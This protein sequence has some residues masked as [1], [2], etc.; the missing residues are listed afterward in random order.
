MKA[1]QELKREVND[2]NRSN[3]IDSCE[4]IVAKE[5]STVIEDETFFFLPLKNILK[6]ASKTSFWDHDDPTKLMK[7]FIS[8]TI[9][10]HPAEKETVFLLSSIKTGFIQTLDECIDILSLFTQCDICVQLRDRYQEYIATPSLDTDFLIQ[11]KEKEIKNLENELIKKEP[12]RVPLIKKPEDF[13]PN[14]FYAVRD[15]KL[16][17]VRYLIEKEGID[18]DIRNEEEDQNKDTPLFCGDTPLHVACLYG[19][20]QIVDYLLH[21][22]AN[23]DAQNDEGNTPLHYAYVIKQ[24]APEYLISKGANRKIANHDGKIPEESFFTACNI[25]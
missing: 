7:T 13:E 4:S 23:I 12:W 20:H 2:R 17:S 24:V 8:K 10:A 3:I 16:D 25:G 11:Q 1:F 9:E 19:H 15:G 14:I 6:I 18:V 21:M 22:G 5:L